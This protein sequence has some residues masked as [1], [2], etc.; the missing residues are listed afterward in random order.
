MVTLHMNSEYSASIPGFVMHKLS[1][2]QLRLWVA[3]AVTGHSSAYHATFAWKIFGVLNVDA[4]ERALHY[5]VKRNP[6]LRTLFLDTPTGPMQTIVATSD[7]VFQ[8]GFA[9]Q[10]CN[11]DE[12]VTKA[13]KA[14]AA[15]PFKLERELPI[16]AEILRLNDETHLFLLS[17]HHLVFDGAAI[18][19]ILTELEHAYCELSA[20]R[21]LAIEAQSDEY[22]KQLKLLI[23]LSTA[24]SSDKNAEYWRGKLSGIQSRLELPVDRARKIDICGN[25]DWIPIVFGDLVSASLIDLAGA[26]RTSIFNIVAG[27]IMSLIYRYTGETDLCIGYPIENRSDQKLKEWV[28]CMVNTLPLRCAVSSHQHFYSLIRELREQVFE[29]KQHSSYLIDE[30]ISECRHDLRDSRSPF[31]QIIVNQNLNYEPPLFLDG[32]RTDTLPKQTVVVPFEV[33]WIITKKNPS[34]HMRLEYN[35]DLFD[36]STIERLVGHFKTLLEAVVAN[37]QSRIQD[38]PLLTKAER[39]QMLV[40]WNDTKADFPQDKCIHQLFEEQVG[41][42]P[43]AVAVVFEDQQ[44]T[45]TQLNAKANQ[46]ARHLRSLGVKPDTLVAICVE[47]SLEMVIG[48]L[49]ILKAGGAYVPLDPSYPRDR[50]TM[51]VVDSRPT[52]LLTQARLSDRL[53]SH[54]AVTV[55]LDA[56]APDV[57]ELS[58]NLDLPCEPQ[59]LAYCIYTSGSTGQPKGALNSHEGLVNRLHWMQSAYGLHTDDVVLQKTPFSFD[60]SVWELFWPLIVG[61][62][63][64][65][66]EP[67]IHR[68]PAQL[69]DAIDR[70]GVT[71]LHFVPSMLQMFIDAPFS[72]PPP[73]LR[74]IF[75]SGEALAPT[76][77]RLCAHRLPSIELHNLYGPTECAVDV[78]AWCCPSHDVPTSVSIGKPI[79]NLRIHVL[80]EQ[81]QPTPVGVGGEIHI[82]GIG[83][84]RGYLNRPE[85]T[86][87][88]F[89]PNPFG[90]PGSRMYKTGDLAR[91]LPDGNIEFLGRIDY[92]VKIR[93][94]RIELG[95]V[96][97][98]LRGCEGVRE[99]VVLAREDVPGDKRLVAYVVP[100]SGALAI[101][102]LR[103]QISSFLPEFM[104]PSAWVF[105]DS[106][107]LSPNGKID[108]NRLPAPQA[109]ASVEC[110]LPL[111]IVEA[112][113]N[114]PILVRV[115]E[116]LRGLM[117]A[118]TILPKDDLFTNGFHSLLLIR[119]VALCREQFGVKL[120]LREVYRHGSGQRIAERIG[121]MSDVGA[122]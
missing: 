103:T 3:S 21:A 75:A 77:M 23:N 47:R 68:D 38:L 99:A 43:D 63:L 74:R 102:E 108:R 106:L 10:I 69:R 19:M 55:L 27:A 28:G 105:L 32:L 87:E 13:K 8:R 20:G 122:N 67:D 18:G 42:T 104:V 93:G 62:R 40:E 114:D 109:Q 2:A 57:T 50:L 101:A 98:A 94:F 17:V 60:V 81:L 52:I 25:G 46:L 83:V 113:N 80:D 121:Q 73:S 16:R 29:G 59:Q 12:V 9:D 85:Q 34:L 44:L 14:Q 1:P 119:F 11:Q 53:P 115:M 71:T 84:G 66:A 37:P 24:S 48:L 89:I 61:A 79:A 30:F 7:I 107:P 64:A 120:S 56:P 51:M 86:A 65:M 6:A 91:Y 97:A 116:I 45:Y 88:K 39:H 95:E 90:E 82:A 35:S 70:Y 54:D 78:T 49:G 4:L 5:V 26:T 33:A 118:A 58:G 110:L 100:M 92:Q 15:R 111:N 22:I 72:V 31:S 96:E 36:R 76:T 112:D 41:R 117:P